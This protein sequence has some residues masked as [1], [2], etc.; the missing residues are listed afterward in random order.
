ME[1]LTGF[2]V[3]QRVCKLSGKFGLYISLHVPRELEDSGMWPEAA[4]AA[5]FLDFAT[6][7]QIMIDGYGWFLF[8]AQAEMEAAFWQCV[9]DDGPTKANP[10]N[11]PMRVY[12]ITCSSEGELWNENT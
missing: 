10:Y 2:D 9:G 3:L 8:D 7:A 6:H 12:A 4:Q 11:G 5:T 1:S